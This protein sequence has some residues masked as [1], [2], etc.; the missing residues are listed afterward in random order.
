MIQHH[1]LLRAKPYFVCSS[2]RRKPS[3]RD[4]S[5][6]TMKRI[7]VRFLELDL[8]ELPRD[9]DTE[10]G[11]THVDDGDAIMTTPTIAHS[12]ENTSQILQLTLP[13]VAHSPEKT[14]GGILQTT[15]PERVKSPEKT[16]GDITQPE[17][18]KS[19]EQ[20]RSG[21]KKTY[22][23]KVKSSSKS[24]ITQ[25]EISQSS[26]E[27]TSCE[28]L[29]VTQPEMAQ[30]SE[31]T[32]CEMLKVT[33][34]EVPESSKPKAPL[35][36]KGKGKSAEKSVNKSPEMAQSLEKTGCNI[37]QITQP[38]I[39]ESSKPKAPLKSKGKSKSAEKSV[40][41]S[42]AM[43]QSSGKTSCSILQITQPEIGE[44]SE[45]KALLDS[46]G[47]KKAQKRT[48]S[49][50]VIKKGI[51]ERQFN[52]SNSSQPMSLDKVMSDEDSENEA[53]SDSDEIEERMRLDQLKDVST[54]DKRF[55]FLWNSFVGRQRV[56][57]DGHI[58]WACEEFT[59]LH[60]KELIYSIT[61]RWQ[62]RLFM[63]K[64][65]KYGLV[66]GK[67]INHC[68]VFL[69]KK[70]AE[71]EAEEASASQALLLLMDSPVPGED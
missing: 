8:N 17:R 32:S 38:A 57:A 71:A 33:Q 1:H 41:K 65:W 46:K 51:N 47:E 63:I 19:S 3:Q 68:N 20:P 48:M 5:S 66:S 23:R 55:M 36:S 40:N 22:K 7:K 14:S 26:S 30:S 54:E 29:Q 67:T 16:S 31:K 6:R 61:M 44:S 70:A 10:N 13:E 2:N 53:Y 56:L 15:Q 24:K 62:W 18:A 37:L 58:P 12:P 45:P 59:K 64:L 50:R 27:K 49:K 21:V 34:S 69:D 25:S 43:A 9:D 4:G 42:P 35:D 28:M 52:H 39:A 60:Q 11:L